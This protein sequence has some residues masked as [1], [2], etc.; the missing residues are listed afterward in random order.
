MIQNILM[1][2]WSRTSW[3]IDRKKTTWGKST[4]E[5]QIRLGTTPDATKRESENSCHR[6]RL[7]RDGNRWGRTDELWC[8][9]HFSSWCFPWLPWHPSFC[10][11]EAEDSSDFE[12]SEFTPATACVWLIPSCFCVWCYCTLSST[13]CKCTP[14]QQRKFH[15]L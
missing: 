4:S 9:P 10:C 13:V 2:W 5:K 15:Q 7:K 14:C 6:S 8:L 11:A 3:W 1:D 12:F